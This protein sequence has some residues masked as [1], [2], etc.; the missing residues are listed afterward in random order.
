MRR[1]MARFLFSV[2]VTSG[3]YGQAV[4]PGSMSSAVPATSTVEAAHLSWRSYNEG[5]PDLPSG[6]T[7]EA[8]A[9]AANLYAP[10]GYKIVGAQNDP[11]SGFQAM[12]YQ[13]TDGSG[14]TTI[15]IRGTELGRGG[16]ERL[17]DLGFADIAGIGMNE[18]VAPSRIPPV[19]SAMSP[20]DPR[21]PITNAAISVTNAAIST[22]ASAVGDTALS[23]QLT[24]AKEFTSRIWRQASVGT[25]SFTGHSLGGA[26]AQVEAARTG[27]A[28]ETF[29]APGMRQTVDRMCAE[30]TCPGQS[31]AQ[32]INH[33]RE[34]DFVGARGEHVGRV[35]GHAD[36]GADYRIVGAD[37]KP[38]GET[39]YRSTGRAVLDSVVTGIA[40][41]AGLGQ[42]VMDGLAAITQGQTFNNHP[43]QS[44]YVDLLDQ[45]NRRRADFDATARQNDAAARDRAA[46]QQA[47]NDAVQPPLPQPQFHPSL[48][49]VLTAPSSFAPPANE[50][51]H[52]RGDCTQTRIEATR[53]WRDLQQGLPHQ[54]WLSP[55]AQ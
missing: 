35:N 8:R 47:A 49:G 51:A 7:D 26:I 53:A 43:M 30:Q 31:G 52:N 37:G 29:N 34:G 13:R 45:R 19:N 40:D 55:R 4:P 14:K 3:A 48:S 11:A 20:G 33:V 32:I 38:T 50:R 2:L 27:Y 9:R 44:L 36:A 22:T 17:N 46:A 41:G 18:I 28:A 5:K 15:A 21:I 1:N 24:Q 39:L 6:Y 10:P 16:R 54:G 42:V 23:G 12:A 25:I